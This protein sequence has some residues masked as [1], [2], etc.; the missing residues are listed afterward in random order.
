MMPEYDQRILAS[1]RR[2]I[3][4]ELAKGFPG[5]PLR[6]PEAFRMTPQ[7]KRGLLDRLRER[8]H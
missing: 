5:G 7:R 1:N 2:A 3:D 8:R 4:E 6:N